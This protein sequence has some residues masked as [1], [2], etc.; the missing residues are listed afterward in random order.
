[1]N[2]DGFVST[3]QGVLG[4]L[5]TPQLMKLNEEEPILLGSS[6]LTVQNDNA[7]MNVSL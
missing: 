7:T 5:Q 1:M 4:N 3:G 2:A 6:S